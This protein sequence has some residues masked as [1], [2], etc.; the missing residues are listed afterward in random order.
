MAIVII[1]LLV[2]FAPQIMTVFSS[3]GETIAAG[4]HVI[5]ALSIGYLAFTVGTVFDLAQAGAGDT[6]S[7][8]IINLVS[9]WLIQVPLAY[10]LSQLA[11]LEADGIW[12]ALNLGWVV[13]AVLLNL[14][15]RQGHWKEAQVV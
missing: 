15:F 7:P 8:M 1:G 9:L 3:D 13:Q 12:L 2:L 10:S 14:R 4:A 11:G 5:R 6:L